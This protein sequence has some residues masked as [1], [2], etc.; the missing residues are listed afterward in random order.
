MFS[1][2]RT[3]CHPEVVRPAEVSSH[4]LHKWCQHQGMKTQTVIYT[5]MGLPYTD[6]PDWIY[7]GPSLLGIWQQQQWL[8]QWGLFDFYASP[9]LH[10]TTRAQLP[11]VWQSMFRFVTVKYVISAAVKVKWPVLRGSVSIIYKSQRSRKWLCIGPSVSPDWGSI[12][13]PE[14][15]SYEKCDLSVV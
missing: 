15:D 13:L 12:S 4:Y 11:S 5:H 7:S 9:N 1:V 8:K 10:S 2:T 14:I 6:T 3:S